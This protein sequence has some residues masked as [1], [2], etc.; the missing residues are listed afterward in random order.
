MPTVFLDPRHNHAR[1][2]AEA[3]SHAEKVCAAAA[4]RL[5]PIRR[6]VL[7]TLAASHKPL[8]AY[9]IMDTIGGPRLAP[10]TVYRALEFHIAHGL[11]HRIASRNAFLACV[12]NHRTGALVTFLICEACGAVGEAPGAAV[13]QSLAAAARSAGCARTAAAARRSHPANPRIAPAHDHF[14][15]LAAL[16]LAPAR[17]RGERAYFSSTSVV[18]A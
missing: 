2:A 3:I 17:R 12:N 16:A 11:V 1:C 8:G 4:Q 18:G 13:G 15:I 14:T 6:K 10:I 5:T 7:E 9:D